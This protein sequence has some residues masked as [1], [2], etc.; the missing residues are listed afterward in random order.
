MRIKIFLGCLATIVVILFVGIN[1]SANNHP[2]YSELKK[3]CDTA[4]SQS[5][6]TKTVDKWMKKYQLKPQRWNDPIDKSFRDILITSGISKSA[7]DKGFTCTSFE[8]RVRGGFLSRHVCYGYFV[9]DSEGLLIEYKIYDIF[10][11]M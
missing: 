4:L 1:P 2:S 8:Q 3:S 6:D 5:P 9:F 10:Y 7:V 11:G